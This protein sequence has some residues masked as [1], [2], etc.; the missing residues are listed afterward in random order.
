MKNVLLIGGGLAVVGGLA[1]LYLKNKKKEEA[2]LTG[3]T[4]ATQPSST[5]PSVTTPTGTTSSATDGGIAP[6]PK[7]STITPTTV[8][9]VTTSVITTPNSAPTVQNQMELDAILDNIKRNMELSR[10]K[11]M[12]IAMWKPSNAYRSSGGRIGAKPSN[13][14]PNIIEKLKNDLSKLGYEVKEGSGGLFL[15]KT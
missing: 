6:L 9:G 15:V 13:P 2:I 7:G 11:Q 14:Y 3:G 8:D 4:S 5:T 10:K 1:Y 12:S